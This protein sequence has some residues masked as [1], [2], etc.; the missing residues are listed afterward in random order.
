VPPHRHR[1][2]RTFYDPDI[3]ARVVREVAVYRELLA[4]DPDERYVPRRWEQQEYGV[5]SRKALAKKYG[6]S[7][8]RMGRMIDGR[9]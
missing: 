5:P 7:P 1:A 9:G 3:L 4:L 8:G 2:G 6:V